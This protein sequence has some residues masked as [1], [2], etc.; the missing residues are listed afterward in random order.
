[1]MDG[2][3]SSLTPER[4]ETLFRPRSIAMVGASD[5][6]FFSRNLYRNVTD[7]GKADHVHLINR[8]GGQVHGQQAFTSFDEIDD[9]VD[10]AFMMVPQAATLE[11]LSAAAAAGARNAVI[12]SAGYAE[13][14]GA[15]RELQAELVSHAESLGMLLLGPNCLGFANFADR[16][17]ATTLPDLPQ[18]SGS[19]ALISQSG[20][21]PLGCCPSLQRAAWNCH[22]S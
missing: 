4:L 6:S 18:T 21:P 9:V 1:M 14:G 3:S 22:I 10:L 8:R 11:A 20:V 12:I 13:V 2:T 7:F 5:K 15:G 16:I 19:V 17:V